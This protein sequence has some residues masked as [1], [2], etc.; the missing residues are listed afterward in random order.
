M[1]CLLMSDAS[2]IFSATPSYLGIH[3]SKFESVYDAL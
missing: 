1:T 2:L 3:L